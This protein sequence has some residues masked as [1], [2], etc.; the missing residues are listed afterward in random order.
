[1]KRDVGIPYI[2]MREIHFNVMCFKEILILD[3]AEVLTGRFKS[4]NTRYY[5][6][7]DPEKLAE[8]YS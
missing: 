6:L 3:E 8:K 7:H 2:T 5:I 1:M 4:V